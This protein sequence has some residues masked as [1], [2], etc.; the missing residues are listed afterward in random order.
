MTK[1]DKILYMQQ[2]L[3]V[4][5]EEM[6]RGLEEYLKLCDAGVTADVN[7]WEVGLMMNK[8]LINDNLRNVA[9]VAFEASR[10]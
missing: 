8:S 2:C 5:K 6:D 1:Y 7:E 9:R 4:A 3:Q 10:R